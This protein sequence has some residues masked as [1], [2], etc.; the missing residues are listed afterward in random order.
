MKALRR[1]V[2]QVVQVV[3]VELEAAVPP[4]VPAALPPAQA[5][6]PPQRR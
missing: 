2:H 6:A 4:Q 5:V 3:Q 1:A